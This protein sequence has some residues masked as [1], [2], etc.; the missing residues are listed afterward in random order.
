M[1]GHNCGY[2]HR[3]CWTWTHV[4][5]GGADSERSTFE[6]LCY[7]MPLGLMFRRA[8]LWHKGRKYM[9]GKLRETLRDPRRLAWKIEGEDGSGAHFEGEITGREGFVHHLP[10]AKTDCS[11]QFEVAND[12]LAIA[13]LIMK[14]PSQ[15]TE[16]LTTDSG[17]VL[18]MAGN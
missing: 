2:R 11:G 6:A 4:H 13:R 16:E 17:A 3:G 15:G 9:F 12:S 7:D 8:V 10:Y 5:F 14:L 1:Q 18:E